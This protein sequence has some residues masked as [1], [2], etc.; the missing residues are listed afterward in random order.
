MVKKWLCCPIIVV[1]VL[2][3][4]GPIGSGQTSVLAPLQPSPTKDIVFA[5]GDIVQQGFEARAEATGQLMKKSLDE[6]PGSIA[7]LLGDNSNDDG[8]PESFNRLDRTVWGELNSRYQGRIYAAMGNHERWFDKVNPFHFF[9]WYNSAFDS[10]GNDWFDLHRS[11]WR[12]FR[13][14]SETMA[15][16]HDLLQRM[17]RRETLE[18]FER[19]LRRVPRDMCTAVFFHRPPFSSGNFA[20]PGWVMPL[21][22]KMYRYGVDWWGAGHDHIRDSLPPLDPDGNVDWTYGIPGDIV[23]TGGAIPHSLAD[24]RT[25]RLREPRWKAYGEVVQVNALGILRL[26]VEPGKLQRQF[27]AVTREPG[28]EYPKT[29]ITCHP[30]KP[31]YVESLDNPNP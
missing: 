23:G 2:V 10:W 18:W 11:G 30:N 20:S 25:G 1:A 16:S 17:R 27:I 7:L 26:D 29:T 13:V 31:G 6:N 22:R 24:P 28:V 4:W 3:I 12:F 21:Y 8:S 19:E 9:Y 14:N 5:V 15:R